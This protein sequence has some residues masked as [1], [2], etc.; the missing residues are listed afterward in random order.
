MIMAL[1]VRGWQRPLHLST[2]DPVSQKAHVGEV[3]TGL[4]TDLDGGVAT[5][6]QMYLSLRTP[7]GRR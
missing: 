4:R 2:A 6:G 5:A 3:N 7:F 1:G